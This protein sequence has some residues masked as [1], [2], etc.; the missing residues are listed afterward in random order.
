MLSLIIF[1]VAS[2]IISIFSLF[3]QVEFV[4]RLI[5]SALA[6]ICI[7]VPYY[8]KKILNAL[9]KDKDDNEEEHKFYWTV[10]ARA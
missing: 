2:I 9:P 8:A 6:S 7:S 4:D 3:H 5:L 1:I 10:W